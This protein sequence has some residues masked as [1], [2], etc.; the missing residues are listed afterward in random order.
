METPA[1]AG[2]V[3]REDEVRCAAEPA[4]DGVGMLGRE[5]GAGRR[6]ETRERV[7]DTFDGPLRDKPV[8]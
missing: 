3:E 4:V 5:F 6:G 8:L 1:E 2:A 7:N